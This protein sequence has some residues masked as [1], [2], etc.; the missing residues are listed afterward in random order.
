MR[1]DFTEER[2]LIILYGICKYTIVTWQVFRFY[3]YQKCAHWNVRYILW[4]F[5][6]FAC[7]CVLGGEFCICGLSKV[8]LGRIF[9]WC[10]FFLTWTGTED[11]VCHTYCKAPLTQIVTVDLR[12]NLAWLD[13]MYL[14]KYGSPS[15]QPRWRTFWLSLW[16]PDWLPAKL[17]VTDLLFLS[18]GFPVQPAWII[19]MADF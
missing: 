19:Y 11:V 3:V 8:S 4:F 13:L 17:K 6:S 15:R 5:L 14:Q 1:E 2:I 7:L 18:M 12:Q 10:E 9:V 16:L